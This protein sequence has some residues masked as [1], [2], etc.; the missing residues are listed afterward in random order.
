MLCLKRSEGGAVSGVT[1]CY[2]RLTWS[3][4]SN[5]SLI[6]C[7]MQCACVYVCVLMKICLFVYAINVPSSFQLCVSD[8]THFMQC[9]WGRGWGGGSEDCPPPAIKYCSLVI[10]P[11]PNG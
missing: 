5:D 4:V 8:A 3:M 7:I 10:F 1:L 9:K 2:V 11:Y 6:V